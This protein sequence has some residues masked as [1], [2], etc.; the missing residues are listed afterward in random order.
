MKRHA[1]FGGNLALAL[2]SRPNK[3]DKGTSC[4]LAVLK[5]R[6]LSRFGSSV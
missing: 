4:P 1:K 6:F 5:F 3:S 2:L